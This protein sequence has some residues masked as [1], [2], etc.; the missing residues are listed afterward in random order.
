MLAWEYSFVQRLFALCNISTR[1]TKKGM[2]ANDTQFL[3]IFLFYVDVVFLRRLL[4]M[5][6]K[7]HVDLQF[8]L[9]SHGYKGRLHNT[10]SDINRVPCCG[11][12]T[13]SCFEF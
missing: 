9:F 2:R 5:L 11:L 4:F 10:L 1:L 12:D 7:F 6:I 8:R 3:L 13:A